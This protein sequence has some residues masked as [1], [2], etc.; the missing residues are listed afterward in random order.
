[1]EDG[2]YWYTPEEG[3]VLA[4]QQPVKIVNDEM[5][6]CGSSTAYPVDTLTGELTKA[7]PPIRIVRLG[8]VPRKGA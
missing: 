7:G 4:E 5:F 1:M 2:Y 8:S 3:E 6:V